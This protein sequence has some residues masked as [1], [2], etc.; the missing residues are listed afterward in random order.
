[1]FLIVLILNGIILINACKKEKTEELEFDTQT[2]EDNS[3]AEGTFNDVISIANQALEDTALTTY[4][5]GNP[6]NSILNTCATVTNTPDGNGGGTIIVN[7]GTTNCECVDLR[8][9]RGIINI[10]YTG[11]Y[12]DSGTEI[13]TSFDDYFVGKDISHMYQVTGSK[14]VTNN[15]LNTSGNPNFSVNV[16]GHLINSGNVQMDWTSARNREWISG[17]STPFIWTDDEYVI[18]GNSSGTNFEGNSFIANITN[19]LHIENCRWITQ[20]TFELTPSGKPV[21]IFDYG[22]GVCDDDAVLTVNGRSFQITLR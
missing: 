8:F 13:T 22:N 15:G 20:G 21:R 14:T 11:A 10:H 18:I 5:L 3:L 2:A 19:G 9:R 16:S 17:S 1:M 4:R 12:R 7:F 6:D